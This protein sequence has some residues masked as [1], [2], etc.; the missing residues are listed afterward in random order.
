MRMF[1]LIGL[2]VLIGGCAKDDSYEV[3]GL[4]RSLKDPDPGVRYSA[5]KH[6]G[7]YGVQAKTAIP[8]LI[9][10][11]GDADK[12]VRIG[13]IQALAKIGPTAREALPALKGMLKD[14]SRGVRYGA[15]GAST[16]QSGGCRYRAECGRRARHR[17][18]G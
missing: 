4:L 1:M 9:D 17:I 18:N 11:L 16:G 12:D 10:A 13:A 14:K 5:V 7:K 2:I 15:A 3:P 6:L 8:A